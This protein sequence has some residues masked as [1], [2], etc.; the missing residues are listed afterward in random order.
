MVQKSSAENTITLPVS[1]E[2]ASYMLGVVQLDK[3]KIEALPASVKK[4]KP[5]AEPL[6]IVSSLEKKLESYNTATNAVSM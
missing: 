4:K 6:K 3:I 1:P 5:I 2:E